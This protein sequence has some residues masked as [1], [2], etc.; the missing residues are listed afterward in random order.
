MFTLLNHLAQSS[1]SYGYHTTHSDGGGAFI[2]ILLVGLAVASVTII[3]MWEV[4]AKAGKPGWAAIIPIYNMLVLLQIVGRP[5]WWILL[6]LLGFIPFVGWIAS[7]VVTIIIY[8]ELIKAFGKSSAF[9]VLLL[10]LPFVGF[11][12][13]G[14]GRATYKKPAGAY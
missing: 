1:Y 5:W 3:S 13:L 10:L 2:A 4:F 8:N 9:T 7:L 14:F 11:P 6:Y 12:I